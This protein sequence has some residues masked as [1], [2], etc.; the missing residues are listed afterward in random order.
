LLSR[1]EKVVAECYTTGQTYKQIAAQL[2]IA[3]AT[4]RNHLAAIYRKLGVSNKAELIR[5]VAESASIGTMPLA[6]E[7]DT[8][9]APVLKIL[10]T[11]I[12]PAVAEPSIAVLPFVNIGPAETDYFSHGV[13]VN[14]HNNLTRFRDLFVSGRSSCLALGGIVSDIAEVSKNL[15]VQYLVQGSVRLQANVVRVTAEL[16]D[17]VSGA[18]LWCEQFEHALSDLLELE[19]EIANI[20]AGTLSVRI[21]D[22]QYERRKTISPDQLTAY[23]LQLRGYR[24]LELGGAEKLRQ[25]RREFIH[26]LELE[27]DSAA[28]CAG[29]SMSY[30]Y[31]CDQLLAQNY[32]ES[33][34]RHLEFAEKAI[35]LDESDSRGHYAM[36]CALSLSGQ[37][38]IADLHAVRALELNPNEYHNLCS[39]GYTLMSLN[40]V[41]ESVACFNESLRRNPLAPNSCLLAL[42]L[43]EYLEENYAQSAFALSRISDAYI[44]GSSSLAAAL[45]QLGYGDEARSEGR[46]F[47]RLV[48][49]R[50][51]YPS[52]NKPGDWQEF[53]GLVYPYLKQERID[54]LLEGIAKAGLPV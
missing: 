17:C 2:Y 15:G 28:A 9:T 19:T 21:E 32:S 13:T 38:E 31:E 43:I 40:R 24:N 33:L 48:E 39:R 5:V 26:A 1:R 10:D 37:F 42:G 11:A 54:H 52:G 35:A 49:A 46:E 20:I 4:V 3:P 16:V 53:W 36:V 50:P 25:A 6:F 45:G 14:I 23:D 44:Q 12:H 29:L 47:Q 30:G 27:P 51:G 34:D 8:P 7:S 18:V 41:E 22:A